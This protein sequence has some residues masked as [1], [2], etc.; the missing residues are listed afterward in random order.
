MCPAWSDNVDFGWTDNVGRYT[1]AIFRA[2]QLGARVSVNWSDNVLTSALGLSSG[3]VLDKGQLNLP[4]SVETGSWKGLFIY[5]FPASIVGG[6]SSHRTSLARTVYR[7]CKHPER[8][9]PLE[10]ASNSVKGY[11]DYRTKPFTPIRSYAFLDSNSNSDEEGMLV[12]VWDGPYSSVDDST[13]LLDTKKPGKFLFFRWRANYGR[14]TFLHHSLDSDFAFGE[15]KCK[16]TFWVETTDSGANVQFYSNGVV[17]DPVSVKGP[18]GLVGLVM[19]PGLTFDLWGTALVRN[20][21]YERAFTWAQDRVDRTAQC[22]RENLDEVTIRLERSSLI[23]RS[24]T[25]ETLKKI[26]GLWG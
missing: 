25:E 14:P 12:D 11:F 5:I 7:S 18:P 16:A 26:R 19:W 20:E 3:L 4:E 13:V 8:L 17:S 1:R 2:V 9:L 22:L 6:L 10:A 15:Q 24:Y 23:K 21:E